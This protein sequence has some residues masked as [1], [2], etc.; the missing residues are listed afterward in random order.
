MS[1]LRI[2]MISALLAP[3]ACA[4]TVQVNAPEKPIEI[5]MNIK[6]EHE[7]RIKVEKEVEDLFSGNED[8]FGENL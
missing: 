3:V 2:A 1:I 5:N 8:I 4:P 6:I 7:I